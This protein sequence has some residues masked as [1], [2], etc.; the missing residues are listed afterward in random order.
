MT[1]DALDEAFQAGLIHE[2]TPVLAP[3][4]FAWAPLS[5]VAGL[6]AE[7]TT[8]NVTP[9]ISPVAIS[10]YDSLPP[11]A[12]APYE[13]ADLSDDALKPKRGKMLLFGGALTAG[14]AAFAIT[15]ALPKLGAKLGS[16]HPSDIGATNAMQAPPAAVD[17]TGDGYS[18]PTAKLTEE[19]KRLLAEQD[20]KREEAAKARAAKAA[21]EAAQKAVKQHRRQGKSKQPFVNGGDKFDPLN[22]SL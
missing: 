5:E 4:A 8:P 18:N 22:G 19:Q 16:V 13:I 3:G 17:V 15:F 20:K 6:E 1:L 7:P 14:L 21:E 9:S 2:Q 10:N 12:P 11:P